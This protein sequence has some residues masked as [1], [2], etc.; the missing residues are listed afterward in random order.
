VAAAG[1]IGVTYFVHNGSSS[2][3]KPDSTSKL[4]DRQLATE[5]LTGRKL[6]TPECA[7][8]E[9]PRWVYPVAPPVRGLPN[10]V[11][12]IRSNLYEVFAIHYP[13]TKAAAW[14][15]KLSRL[16]IPIRHNGNETVLE[17]PAG[18]FCS[19]WPDANGRAYAGAC[20]SKGGGDCVSKS[21][22]GQVYANGRGCTITGG[23]QAF[24][25]NWNVA[26]RR[27]VFQ[28]DSNNVL[29]LVHVSGADTNVVF[30]YLN[31]SYELEVLNTSGI[32]YLD[33]FTWQ[34]S[35][36]WSVTRIKSASGAACTLTKAGKIT[37]AGRVNPP[38]CLCTD[39]GG[40]VSVT[41]TASPTKKNAGYLFGGS[42]W[43][44]K[45]TKMTPVP[46]II[47][48]SPDEAAKRNGV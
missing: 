14:I 4:S 25:W 12:N 37:C 10:I 36:G 8:V 38:S 47:P 1:V 33:G 39:D 9:G 27:V 26:N 42:P 35:P 34:P 46:Y 32:G 28:H 6:Q 7:P 23:R 18:F 30:H 17:G 45:V 31:G 20:Q 40:S 13:C 19:A 3:P 22:Y 48:G 43:Q 41:F 29:H 24:G 5:G 44:F 15:H 11:A 21:P 16:K 2:A